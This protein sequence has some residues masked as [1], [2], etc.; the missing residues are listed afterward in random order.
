MSMLVNM[1][2]IEFMQENPG[3]SVYNEGG[4]TATGMMALI[5]QQIDIC[6]ASRPMRVEE[7]QKLAIKHNAIGIRYLVGKDALSVYINKNN[8][9][10]DLTMEQIKNIFKG[11]IKNWQE[12][13]GPN[14][15]IQVIIRPP[16]SGTFHYFKEHVLEGA[17]YSEKAITQ[18]TTRAVAAFIMNNIAAIGYG[19]MAFSDE[20]DHVTID[21]I[22]ANMES[23]MADI[24]PITRYL[25]F[26]TINTPTG[27]SKKFIDWVQSNA[28]QALVRKAGYYP[29]WELD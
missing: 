1:W 26:Y 9:V 7:A 3:Y 15:E 29:I 8:P 16:N 27:L 14:R 25:Y 4:G 2:A 19:G 13:G 20:I 10:K 12:I 11:E 22:A 21:G 6:A 24:Y 28:G 23:V 5:D 18:N 17:K